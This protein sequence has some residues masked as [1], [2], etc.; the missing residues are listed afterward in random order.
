MILLNLFFMSAH[1][2]NKKPTSSA[3]VPVT[4]AMLYA[5]RDEL[6][7]HLMSHDKR[8]DSLELKIDSMF[9]KVG[10]ALDEI[11]ADLH[12]NTLLA[13]E[14][15]SRNIYVLDQYELVNI[16]YEKLE[17]RVEHYEKDLIDLMKARKT[18]I[19]V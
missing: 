18:K 4:Q 9:A 5:V 17:D 3:D 2:K 15:N 14:Q 6:K 7:S 10:S 12:K 11:K 19:E 1:K 13:E 8:F 16:R